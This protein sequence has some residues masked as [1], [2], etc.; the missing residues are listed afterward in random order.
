MAAQADCPTLADLAGLLRSR[1]PH[2]GS[3]GFRPE[4]ATPSPSSARGRSDRCRLRAK[5]A[6]G[7]GARCGR[8]A[9]ARC[10]AICMARA[11]G[12]WPAPARRC[13][14]ARARGPPA[15]RSRSALADWPARRGRRGR[16]PAAAG[17]WRPARAAAPGLAQHRRQG[18]DDVLG[19]GDQ[20][21]AGLEQAVGALGARI[22]GMAG[23]GEHLAALLGGHA[24]GDQRA[25]AARRLDDQHAQRDAGDDA[26][27]AR[28]ILRAGQKPG[29]FSL[30]RQPRSPM[31]R[32][33]L[34]VLGRIDVVDAA[35][36]HGDGAVRR[37]PPR[38]PPRRCRAPGR[39]R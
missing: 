3:G 21:R 20:G 5:P 13:R 37:G 36:E 4:R 23:H 6:D 35:G 16:R 27:A 24:R 12:P 25:G 31:R 1:A 17:S 19:L 18:L 28:E 30:T 7:R 15:A 11:P 2:R 38:G 39:R 32:C 10:R 34:G 22:E 14:P 26:V 29:G 33:K 9:P 8:P